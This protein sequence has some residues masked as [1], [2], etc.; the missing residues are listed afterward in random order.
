MIVVEARDDALDPFELEA[1]EQRADAAD[2]ARLVE[3]CRRLRRALAAVRSAPAGEDVPEADRSRADGLAQATQLDLERA[4]HL[5]DEQGIPR[6]WREP[7]AR[8][9][10][11]YSLLGRLRLALGEDDAQA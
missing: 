8:D 9:P 6:T 1:I 7:G 2:V 11:E 10:S 5:L 4:H 3:E